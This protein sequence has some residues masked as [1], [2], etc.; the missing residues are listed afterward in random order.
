MTSLFF[1]NFSEAF[2]TVY[3][4]SLLINSPSSVSEEAV[5]I[6]LGAWYLTNSKQCVSIIC[7]NYLQLP[8]T[9]VVPQGSIHG[10]L[11]LVIFGHQ[12]DRIHDLL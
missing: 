6:R 5:G 7:F 10:P 12:Q 8:I 3:H 1:F 4:V 2:D 9:I 11:K